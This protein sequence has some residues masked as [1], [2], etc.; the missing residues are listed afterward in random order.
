VDKITTISFDADGTLWNFKQAMRRALTSTLNELGR[1]MPERARS[2]SVEKMIAIRNQ[3]AQE[4]KGAAHE[5]IRL[6]AFQRTLQSI[7]A[8]DEALAERLCRMYLERR[9]NDIELY[10]DAI[11]TLDALRGEYT[12]G[13]LSNGNTYPDRCGLEGLFQFVV[14]AQDHDGIEKP[15]P[16]LFEI[17]IAQAGCAKR[18]CLHVGDSLESDVAGATGAGIK[19]AW[20]NRD[21][22]PNDSDARPDFE[23]ETLTELVAICKQG[24]KNDAENLR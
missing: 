9:F 18:E 5:Q 21:G 8:A 20:L 11:P 14:F 3:T 10:D 19:A 13:L 2:L 1:I 12:L 6:A 15:D 24:E 23:I 4:L 22:R 7:E 17:A 16:R